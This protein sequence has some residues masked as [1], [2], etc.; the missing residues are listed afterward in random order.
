M[1]TLFLSA[2]L[3]AFALAPVRAEM[4]DMSTVTCSQ[5]GDL[6]EDNGAFFLI[7]LD[8]W[9]AGQADSTTF[10]PDDL[11]DQIEGIATLCEEQPELSVMNA[12]KQYLEEDE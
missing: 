6:G 1:K 8:G 10:D 7:W 4:L 2:A 3:A 9:L 12:A 11:N 5:L